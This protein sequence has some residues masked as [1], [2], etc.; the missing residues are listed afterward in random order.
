MLVGAPF[1]VAHFRKCGRMIP[2]AR[3]DNA[4]ANVRHKKKGDRHPRPPGQ[5]RLASL[6]TPFAVKLNQS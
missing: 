4:R 2:R 6:F 3:V 1:F 5:C